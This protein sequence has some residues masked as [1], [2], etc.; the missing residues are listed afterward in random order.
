MEHCAADVHA[1]YVYTFP[2]F[3]H[4]NFSKISDC[5]VFPSLPTDLLS[6]LHTQLPPLSL[7]SSFAAP[8][9]LF[10]VPL[11]L[12]SPPS[13]FSSPL[14]PQASL[15]RHGGI[16][17][18]VFQSRVADPHMTLELSLEIN[19]K[20]QAVLEDTLLKNITIKVR[21]GGGS[22]LGFIP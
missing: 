20:L 10:N 9:H 11:S 6:S 5:V 22:Y 8:C 18:S 3:C 7:A 13:P 17:A 16:M 1:F 2:S 12:P 15:S 19:R 4:P 14:T 21:G